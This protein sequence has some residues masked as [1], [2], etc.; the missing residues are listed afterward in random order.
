LPKANLLQ[1]LDLSFNFI[2]DTG[3]KEI[4]GLIRSAPALRSLVLKGNE[5][6]PDGCVELMNTLGSGQ[7]LELQVLDLSKNPL[8]TKGGLAISEFLQR[9]TVLHELDLEDTKLEIDALIALAAV[10]H[11]TNT[12]LRALQVS[13][14]SLFTLQE[15]HVNHFGSMLQMNTGLKRVHLG[16][17]QIYDSGIAVLV[18]YLVW[19]RTLRVLDL[20]KNQIGW[21]GAH[22]LATLLQEDCIIEDLDL[23]HNR[24]GEKDETT[25]AEAL[26][27]ALQ[28]NRSL[29]RLNLNDNQLCGDA[30]VH[31]AGGVAVNQN[32]QHI[33]VFQNHWSQP[34]ARRFD[35]IFSDTARISPLQADFCTYIVDGTFHIAEVH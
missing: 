31:I 17:H 35:R 8:A 3:V 26:G 9:N 25:G 19:N 5:I 4:C 29:L 6:G 32:I 7:N 21:R 14:P 22:S 1:R 34:A 16:M 28:Q 24:L 33:S 18:H 20:S 2:D 23:S 13:R 27:V 10:L 12:T 11:V 15:E 30:L